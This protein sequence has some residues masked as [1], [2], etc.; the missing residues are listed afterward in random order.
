VAGLISPFSL[1]D[2][3]RQWL[4]GTTPGAVPDP[5]GTWG[6][7]YALLLLTLAAG[8]V[9]VLVTRYRKAGAS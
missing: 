7:G 1:L 2:G 9:A 6:A 4:G 5:G 8:S 3:V